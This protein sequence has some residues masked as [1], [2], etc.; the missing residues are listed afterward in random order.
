MSINNDELGSVETDSEVHQQPIVD[1]T[2]TVPAVASFEE[3]GL[4]AN[5]IAAVRKIGWQQPTPV[6]GMCLPLT[7]KGRDVAGFAQT[8]TG[9]TG[10]FVMTVAERLCGQQPPKRERKDVAVP[11][12]LV[13]TPTRELT[14][15]IDDDAQKVIATL[16][17]NSVPVFGGVDLE[18]QATAFK[19]GPRMIVATPGRL[20]DFYQRKLI[21]LSQVKIF[22]CDEADRMFDMGFIDDVEFFL[23]K[24]PED[25]Q[26]LLF[27]ATTNDNVK[28]LAFEYLNQPAY[29]SVNPE[30][31]TPEA[32]DQHAVICDT[33]NKLR[34]ILGLLHEH[35]PGCS[36][37]FTNTKMT[38]EWL[39]YKLSGNGIDV[40]LI[41]GDL[42]QKKRIQLIHRIK[43]GKVKA[44]IATD[45]A[46]RGLHISKVTHVY[47]FDVPDDPANYVHRIGRTARAGAKG[48]SYTLV[49]EDY[50]EN[51][52]AIQDMLG[53]QVQLKGEWFNPEYLEI[54][55]MAGNPYAVGGALY[56]EPKDRHDR[57]GVAGR[58]DRGARGEGKEKGSGASA[59]DRSRGSHKPDA[60][61]PQGE[62]RG[63]METKGPR[64][65]DRSHKGE[66]HFAHPEHKSQ[67]QDKP[68]VYRAEGTPLGLF[69]WVAKIFRALFGAR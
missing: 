42:P 52:R 16:G 64:G 53:P 1:V 46:S 10:V 40:D 59:R 43:E 54:S 34:V 8:G 7:T 65:K 12:V 61:S 11:E 66:K 15:Q 38:A 27:S 14:M 9:K 37:I 28:E 32:I 5:V 55:D 19:E 20:K 58:G 51:I 17:I 57:K 67:R 41:T 21:D 47:N 23:D 26:K 2:E 31:L 22:I 35:K 39:H 62:Y 36:I 33:S 3:A 68:I 45:V 44:L 49:C 13:L 60:G 25:A 63:R 6:Q 48:S 24:I 4:S 69:G 29:I 56:R 50:G 18:K 30:V